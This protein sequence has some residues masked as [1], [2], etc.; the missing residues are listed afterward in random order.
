[1]INSYQ[2]VQEVHTTNDYEKFGLLKYNRDISQAHIRGIMKSINKALNGDKIIIEVDSDLNIIDG[3]HRFYALKKLR[4][5]IK[6]VVRQNFKPQDLYTQ[7]V[8]KAWTNADDLKF[9]SAMGHEQAQLV[10]EL[11]KRYKVSGKVLFRAVFSEY[12]NSLNYQD[13]VINFDRELYNKFIRFMIFYE[14]IERGW[15]DAVSSAAALKLFTRAKFVPSI[16]FAWSLPETDKDRLK[17]Q[18][19][20][21]HTK[22]LAVNGSAKAFRAVEDV[23][24]YKLVKEDRKI[25][26]RFKRD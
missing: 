26:L 1:M 22:L 4:L 5:P 24:N 9:L 6:Y 2:Q 20:R 23:Y 17:L 16:Y 15:E 10:E 19:V 7:N 3:Q 12:A 18:L 13:L 25:Y 11:T 21:F 14:E 8:A